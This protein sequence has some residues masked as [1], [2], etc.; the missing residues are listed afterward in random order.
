VDRLEPGGV[1]G[2]ASGVAIAEAELTG[3]PIKAVTWHDL[4][5]VEN[6]DLWWARVIFD[7]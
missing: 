3:S 1:Q 6:P 4:V 5:V 2:A 7:T